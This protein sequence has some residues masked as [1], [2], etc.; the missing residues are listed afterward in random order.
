MTKWQPIILATML[1][2]S[3]LAP[4][5]ARACWPDT[6]LARLAAL[7][8]LQT[9]NAELL[10]HASATLTLDRWCARHQLATDARIVADRV[11]GEDKQPPAEI[12]AQLRAGDAEPV[13]YRRVR[14]RCGERV[15][16]E[17]DNWYL[18]A[19]LTAEMNHALETSDAAFGRVVQPLDFRR[20]TLSAQLFWSPVPEGWD[21]GSAPLPEG[22][23]G[24]SLAIPD[25]VIE[26]RAL[27]VRGDGDPFSYVIETYQGAVL[28]FPPSASPQ[29][30]GEPGGRAACP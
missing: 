11:G 17:A 24:A 4:A 12:R 26:H 25:Q 27:L 5:P 10:G 7:A 16:S 1:A 23:E 21:I 28:D 9:L 13:A 30:G 2:A 22:T 3:A 6:P 15:L 20:H 19:R 18:P 29:L 14:L 8:E